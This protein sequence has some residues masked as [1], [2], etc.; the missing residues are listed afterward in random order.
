MQHESM[1]D[2]DGDDDYLPQVQSANNAV[3]S[4]S[5]EPALRRSSR[6]RARPSNSEVVDI[7]DSPPS[8]PA[9]RRLE[10]FAYVTPAEL[11]LPTDS[12]PAMLRVLVH[13]VAA[14]LI[15]MH[16]HLIKT[17]VIG[18]LGGTVY[19]EKDGGRV[20]VVA[21]AFAVR[22]V[23]EGELSRTGRNAYMEVELD[24]ESS[25]E[26]SSRV[27]GKGLQVVGWYHS[28]PDKMFTVEP[29]RVDIENQ[30][31]YQTLLFK[32][33]PFVA[34]IIAPYNKDLPDCA[35]ALEFWQTWEG[36]IPL[37]LPHQIDSLADVPRI[38]LPQYWSDTPG[39]QRTFPLNAFANECMLL[40]DE[41]KKSAKRVRLATRWRGTTN[42]GDKL[43]TAL[44][45]LG[46]IWGSIGCG[47]SGNMSA[48][49]GNDVVTGNGHSS[50]MPNGP[51]PPQVSI[52]Q[53]VQLYRACIHRVLDHAELAYEAE[54]NREAEER[55]ERRRQNLAQRSK[56]SRKR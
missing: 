55:E 56:R 4:V 28:H 46:N 50:H 52:A 22:A 39:T 15:S 13:P 5:S 6:V 20:V 19:D 1:A 25:V 31:N 47:E 18:M 43:R 36:D 23:A 10:Q 45:A 49:N 41:Y 8:S 34:A 51:E 30:C 33:R 44:L 24:P 9:P 12:A 21:E 32:E 27:E 17:E 7:A 53:Q 3:S 42:C 16:A 11:G 29:S 38:A 2:T 14:A 26:V 37:Q 35:P 48:W 54:A 40:V